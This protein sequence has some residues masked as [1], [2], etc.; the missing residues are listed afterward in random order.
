[1][2]SK[3]NRDLLEAMDPKLLVEAVGDAV[4]PRTIYEAVRE[5]FE[6]ALKLE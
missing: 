2:G 6:A 3:S 5:G 1:V 4:Q